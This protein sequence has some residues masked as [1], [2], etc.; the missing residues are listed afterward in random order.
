MSPT[1]TAPTSLEAYAWVGFLLRR[2]NPAKF[3]ELL[4]ATAETV[5]FLD[6]LRG[7]R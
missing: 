3:D 5:D 2:D 1:A 6:V 4:E 7:S